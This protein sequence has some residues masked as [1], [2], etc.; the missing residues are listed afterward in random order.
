MGWRGRLERPERLCSLIVSDAWWHLSLVTEKHADYT[1]SG[2]TS[3]NF[4]GRKSILE[5]EQKRTVSFVPR[6]PRTHIQMSTYLL[7]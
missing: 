6:Y 3:G 1:A 7:F 5:R 4:W 2:E